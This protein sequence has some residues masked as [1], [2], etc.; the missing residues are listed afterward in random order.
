MYVVC[1][2]YYQCVKQD[3]ITMNWRSRVSRLAHLVTSPLG[4]HA[5]I[6]SSSTV[7]IHFEIHR[8]IH[9]SIRS[10]IHPSIHSFEY[11]FD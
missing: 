3:V 11:P 1:V 2:F 10:N 6:H 7:F 9:S 8:N 5:S 4:C